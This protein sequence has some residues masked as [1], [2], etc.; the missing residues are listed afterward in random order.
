MAIE[1]GSI[2][3]SSIMTAISFV[4]FLGILLWVYVIR[5]NS[6][7]DAAAQ[8]PFDDESVDERESAMEKHHG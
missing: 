1:N 5:R 7:F 2:D 8:L 3:A 6:D 4:T